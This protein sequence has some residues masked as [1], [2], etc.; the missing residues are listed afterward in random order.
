MTSREKALALFAQHYN[1]AQSTLAGCGSLTGLPDEVAFKAA[2][3]FGGGMRIG[4]ICGA[5]TGGLMALGAIFPFTDSERPED[6]AR[7]GDKTTA[8]LEAFKAA[9][10]CLDCEGLVR[11]D[12]EGAHDTVCPGLVAWAAAYVEKMSGAKGI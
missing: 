8:F 12:K 4:S 2:G 5:A 10:G 3:G 6:K 11:G 7:I 9:H 1:C